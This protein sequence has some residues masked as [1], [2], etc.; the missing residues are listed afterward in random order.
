MTIGERIERTAT[1]LADWIDPVAYKG[2]SDA[3]VLHMIVEGA[4]RKLA[5]PFRKL[6]NR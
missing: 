1:R 6:A 2:W 4:G 5:A 3:P